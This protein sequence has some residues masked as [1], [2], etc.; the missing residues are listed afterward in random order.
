MSINPLAS[1]Q[2]PFP[3]RLVAA[4]PRHLIFFLSIRPLVLPF[5]F[6]IM[7]YSIF[8]SWML[9]FCL[10]LVDFTVFVNRQLF[11]ISFE[12]LSTFCD[13]D[14][15]SPRLKYSRLWLSSHILLPF[16]EFSGLFLTFFHCIILLII[17]QALL[18]IRMLF[19]F[20]DKIVVTVCILFFKHWQ[21]AITWHTHDIINVHWFPSHIHDISH[22]LNVKS[23]C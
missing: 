2:L 13:F 23:M 21:F 8:L 17:S 4:W 7:W 1:L 22:G 19:P 12:E 16:I 15:L 6:L 14:H 5:Y 11:L 3:L 9:L 10:V 20:T 18:K